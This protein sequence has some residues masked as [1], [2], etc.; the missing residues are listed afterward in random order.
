M[1][2][3]RKN[4]GNTMKYKQL[5]SFGSLFLPVLL[6]FLCQVRGNAQEIT[7]RVFES[8][9]GKPL[10]N[11]AV[12]ILS[13]GEFTETSDSGYFSIAVPE[14][15]VR[16]SVTMPGYD[17]R[18]IYQLGR[19]NLTISMVP[20]YFSSFDDAV[21]TPISTQPA[22]DIASAFGT[23]SP[24]LESAWVT[25][26]NQLLQ[27]KMAGVSIVDQSGM[28]G[29]KT[30]ASIG[31]IS[32]MSAHNDPLVIIDGMIHLINYSNNTVIQGY[33]PDPMDIVDVDD[34]SSVTVI[35]NGLSY[36]GSTGS[37]GVININ[38][39]Q[40]GETST[41]IKVHAYEGVAFTPKVLPVLDDGEF[42]QYFTGQLQYQGYTPDE[43]NTMY[44]WLNG[45]P[46]SPEYYRY[47]NNTQWQELINQA[48]LLQKYYIFLKGGDDIATY[49]ISTGFLR[50]NGPYD[51]TYYSRYNLRINGRINITDKFSVTPNAKLS[52]SSTSVPELGDNLATNP[53]LAGL[54]K[55]PLMAPYAKDEATGQDLEYIDDVG[56][57]NVSNP[58]ALITNGLGRG[59]SAFFVTSA[60]L[61]YRFNRHFTLQNLTGLDYSNSRQDIFIPDVG[62]IQMDS[63]YNS[64]RSL[65]E[66]YQSTQNHTTF[67]Y[68]TDVNR[69]HQLNLKLGAWFMMNKYAFD[70]GIDLNTA[71]DEFTQIGQGNARLN[72][73]REIDAENR[74][75]NWASFYG[76]M[77]YN[78]LG[79][80]FLNAVL[81]VDGNSATN[82]ESRYNLYPSVAGAWLISAEKFMHP[83]S[84]LD[85]LKVRAGWDKTGN[86]FTSIYDLSK[87][88]YTQRK[89]DNFGVLVRDYIPNEDM[90][91]ETKTS[92]NAGIDI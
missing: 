58:V 28:A 32:S 16:I 47:N 3:N 68:S 70:K 75:L 19:K 78:Y 36:L 61:Q 49:N 6:C 25:S 45:E 48:S 81:A 2:N 35:R 82:L 14:D 43:I 17:Q 31:G 5:R 79:K 76:S 72:Y 69:P 11:A 44:P 22:R 9:T 65:A 33:T 80:Y 50:H 41:S 55:S 15:N 29:Q 24:G 77:N 84:W 66:S 86:M 1:D 30:W 89:F 92:V 63:V 83:L 27:G 62:V 74:G 53:A 85:E 4:N 59:S 26:A 20:S 90:E 18:V 46:G 13:T 64:P 38:T 8:G 7:G 73:L 52:L 34:I 91:L 51:G 42:R 57:F 56:A 23:L 21:F 39:E 54:R 12:T 37:T 87:L 67:I 71:T 10:K 60:K 40:E 88:Y